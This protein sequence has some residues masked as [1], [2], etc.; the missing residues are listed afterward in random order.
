MDNCS[1][2]DDVIEHNNKQIEKLT[3]KND[4]NK[5]LKKEMVLCTAGSLAL[6]GAVI[7]ISDTY[8]AT[9]VGSLITSGLAFGGAIGTFCSKV[10]SEN[11]IYY[12]KQRNEFYKSLNNS[13]VLKK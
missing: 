10:D 5:F 9:F 2:Y 8:G 12:L 6:V 1:N 4:D 3:I 7:S 11:E 13:K